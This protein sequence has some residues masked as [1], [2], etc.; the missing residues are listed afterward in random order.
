M[1]KKT[2]PVITESVIARRE[3]YQDWVKRRAIEAEN[4]QYLD[5]RIALRVM[6]AIDAI[7]GPLPPDGPRTASHPM[8]TRIDP[9]EPHPMATRHPAPV[10]HRVARNAQPYLPLLGG[11]LA[12]FAGLALGKAL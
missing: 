6:D 3:S 7:S 5:R 9:P 4:R 2:N 11:A 8:A 10:L 12:F 1:K